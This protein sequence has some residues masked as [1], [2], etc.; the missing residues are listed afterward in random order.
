[1]KR[2]T[3]DRTSFFSP[4]IRELDQP[5]ELFFFPEFRQELFYRDVVSI[6]LS[7]RT[8]VANQVGPTGCSLTRS[9][10]LNSSQSAVSFLFQGFFVLGV[11]HIQRF[12]DTGA[13]VLPAFY[14]RG[15][16][17]QSSLGRYPG[18]GFR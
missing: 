11:K 5:L 14:R 2:F 7:G 9:D 3:K 12:L 8:V 6:F 1:M 16:Y 18:A 15:F 17:T 4:S 13:L 10:V